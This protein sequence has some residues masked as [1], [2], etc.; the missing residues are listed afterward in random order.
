MLANCGIFVA[1]FFGRFVDQRLREG[2]GFAGPI[3]LL[4]ALTQL[5]AIACFLPDLVTALFALCGLS[6]SG[7]DGDASGQSMSEGAGGGRR[8]ILSSNI[9][10]GGDHAIDED[11]SA[12]SNERVWRVYSLYMSL[13]LLALVQGTLYPLQFAYV[14]SRFPPRYR[15]SQS[16]ASWMKH[17]PCSSLRSRVWF[18]HPL[19]GT[20][21]ASSPLRLHRSSWWA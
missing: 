5:A 17:Y 21:G 7:D 8:G 14:E 20:L 1:P 10:D 19:L 6:G 11:A 4:L 12:S 13:L 15:N 3:C 2:K 18:G 9:F 16:Q